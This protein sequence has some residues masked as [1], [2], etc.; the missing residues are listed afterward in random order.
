[1]KKTSFLE[2]W[3][4][5]P[6]VSV[7]VALSWVM[8]AHSVDAASLVMAFLLAIFIPR[9]IRPFITY[10]PNIEWKAAVKLFFVVLYDIVV[11]NIQVAKLVLGPIDRLQPKWFRVPLETQHEEVNTLLAMIITTT[12]GTVSAGIDQ[13]RGDILVHALSTDDENAEIENIK[14][15]YEKPLMQILVSKQETKHD[16]F[17][18]CPR[19][20]F[21]RRHHFN[22]VVLNS[23]NHR[24]IDC[25]PTLSTRHSLF[26]CNLPHY[27]FRHL[28]GQHFII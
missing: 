17:A 27:Y 11:S 28:L 23:L 6:F 4:P 2:R 10:T 1:M 16:Y 9:L 19:D 14:A 18:L 5:H 13:D 12:P 21:N 3:L 15:R 20:L 22:V 24:S 7:I 26:K 8:L 25:R